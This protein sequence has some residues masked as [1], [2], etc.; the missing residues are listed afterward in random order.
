MHSLT[1]ALCLTNIVISQSL[2]I[3]PSQFEALIYHQFS[4]GLSQCYNF[5][6]ICYHLLYTIVC[7]QI[8]NSQDVLLI[9]KFFLMLKFTI[10]PLTFFFLMSLT[11]FYNKTQL[12]YRL[13]ETYCM[14]SSSFS[15]HV[16]FVCYFYI[17]LCYL[18]Q[19]IISRKII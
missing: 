2:K 19:Y 12:S 6:S 5:S 8:L 10:R 7:S 16:V 15:L 14:T 11:P 17:S 18:Y 9:K 1:S 4:A 3:P 13:W